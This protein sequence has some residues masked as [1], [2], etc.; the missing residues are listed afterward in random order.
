MT[1]DK[2]TA[3]VGVFISV[4]TVPAA[5]N[6]AL[7]LATWQRA[8]ITGCATQLGINLAGLLLAGTVTLAIQ[9]LLSR[10]L[11]RGARRLL[12]RLP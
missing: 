12:S 4:T 10:H 2:T 1:T 3:M 8:E 9:R 7:A 6:L 11:Q 5:G